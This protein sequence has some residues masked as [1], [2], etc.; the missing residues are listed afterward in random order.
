MIRVGISVEPATKH[1][2][3]HAKALQRGLKRHGI[4]SFVKSS[5]PFDTP[6][7]ACWGWRR[8]SVLRD[9]GKQVLVME[10]G[11][12]GD[13]FQWTSLGWNGLNG[14]ADFRLPAQVDD[15]RWRDN[16]ENLMKPWQMGGDR[17]VV[18]GQHPNDA[19]VRRIKFVEWADSVIEK[20]RTMTDTPIVFRP[21]PLAMR[22][23]VKADTL[24][25]DLASA[26]VRA[27]AVVTYNSNSGVD[28]VLAGVPTIAMDE[29]SMAWPVTTHELMPEPPHKV[30]DDWAHRLAWCQWTLP[31][32][33]SGLAWEHVGR[34]VQAQIAA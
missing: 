16:F 12:V 28:A 10:R 31:E 34:D 11:Y 30:R 21:H 5:G 29:G 3:E 25:G 8:G 7:V 20:L 26:L 4:D 9:L 27:A 15:Q 13:R 1:H 33:E 2:N 14:R 17:I 23:R 18:M 22:V 24:H 19:S 32:I 6:V